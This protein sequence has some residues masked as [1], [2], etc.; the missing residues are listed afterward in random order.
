MNSSTSTACSSKPALFAGAPSLRIRVNKRLKAGALLVLLFSLLSAAMAA[1]P[2]IST[3]VNYVSEMRAD[4]HSPMPPAK[5]RKPGKSG[6]KRG[7][8]PNGLEHTKVRFIR[9]KYAGGD[10]DQQMGKGADYNFLLKFS[11]MTGF[12]IAKKTEAIGVAD[13]KRFPKKAAPPFVYLTG[14]QAINMTRREMQ[15]LRWYLLEEGGMLFAD[16]GGGR[17]DHSLKSL[18]RRVLPEKPWIDIAN[19]DII[20]QQPYRFPDGAPPLWHHSGTRA[21][22]I[23]HNGRWV[24]FYHQGDLNDAWQEGG[25]G[26]SAGTRKAAFK[27]GINV[28]NYALNQ[29][30]AIHYGVQ[31]QIDGRHEP[32]PAASP[33]AVSAPAPRRISAIEKELAEVSSERP[34]ESTV[35]LDDMDDEL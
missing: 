11:E 22:G 28:V 33:I 3:D 30:L 31:V 8:W 17:F 10:W 5:G 14:S 27:M 13:L 26:V 20:Y 4:E 18:M 34:T 23:K 1:E 16:N 32:K 29:Y 19:D 12:K 35:S 21:L 25:S 7:A 15:I 2:V 9:L 24:V 6:A